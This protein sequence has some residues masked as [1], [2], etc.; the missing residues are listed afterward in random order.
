MMLAFIVNTN[1]DD[2]PGCFCSVP[3]FRVGNITIATMLTNTL[4]P[5]TTYKIVLLLMALLIPFGID[6]TTKDVINNATVYI[7]DTT[8]TGGSF[9]ACHIIGLTPRKSMN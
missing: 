4:S 2:I 8:V 6:N 3:T 5:T 1:L 7:L 9:W